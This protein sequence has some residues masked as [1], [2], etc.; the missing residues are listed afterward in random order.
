M[1]EKAFERPGLLLLRDQVDPH[2]N[3]ED[4]AEDYQRTLQ[5]QEDEE[6]RRPFGHHPRRTRGVFR[7]LQ[8]LVIYFE[9][10][11][12]LVDPL[13][14]AEQDKHQEQRKDHQ[15]LPAGEVVGE[16]L[17]GHDED[18]FRCLNPRHPAPVNGRGTRPGDLFFVFS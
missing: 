12:V 9:V 6:G 2:R 18:S 7:R 16:L 11:V 8:L 4:A 1:G 5:V 10:P 17:P 14:H 15:E 13:V 3:R